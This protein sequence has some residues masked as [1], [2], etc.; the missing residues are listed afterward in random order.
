MNVQRSFQGDGVRFLEEFRLFGIYKSSHRSNGRMRQNS[1]EQLFY[2]CPC[3]S[4]T[5]TSPQLSS[6]AF[7]RLFSL[8][9]TIPRRGSNVTILWGGGRLM[10]TGDMSLWKTE[11]SSSCSSS[12]SPHREERLEFVTLLACRQ[13]DQL[14]MDYTSETVRWN[15]P[16]LF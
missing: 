9:S 4:P 1:R 12:C 14:A 5:P 7:K 3:P 6:W 16:F 8:P 15:N 10:R 2:P 13:Q 11:E